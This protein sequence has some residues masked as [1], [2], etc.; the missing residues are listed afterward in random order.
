MGASGGALLGDL[1]E[2]DPAAA[3]PRW[4]NLT[5]AIGAPPPRYSAGFAAAGG[6]LYV[7]GGNCG[8]A[9]AEPAQLPP[10]PTLHTHA[11]P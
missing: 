9:G 8:A 7:F 5:A 3:P 6:R 10:I 11:H 1:F 4:A 2:L